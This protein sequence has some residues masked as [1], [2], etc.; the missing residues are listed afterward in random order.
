MPSCREEAFPKTVMKDVTKGQTGA[1]RKHANFPQR[2]KFARFPAAGLVPG[3]NLQ[4]RFIHP[5]KFTLW[6]F[7][8]SKN[9][10]NP[11]F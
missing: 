3:R 5:F 1:A 2:G 10:M 6:L 11:R 7:Q 9:V 4:I 8:V